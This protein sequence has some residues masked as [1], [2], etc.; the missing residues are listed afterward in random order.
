M[1]TLLNG[2]YIYIS[3]AG[4]NDRSGD[5]RLLIKQNVS[6]VTGWTELFGYS[7]NSTYYRFTLPQNNLVIQSAVTSIQYLFRYT[8]YNVNPNGFISGGTGVSRFWIVTQHTGTYQEVGYYDFVPY[9]K[10]NILTIKN[11]YTAAG[12]QTV[13]DLSWV[14]N[15]DLNTGHSIVVTFDTHNLLYQMFA[16]DLEGVGTNGATYRYLD[17]R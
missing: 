14:T 10:P 6:S 11:R 2:D 7:I 8:I 13:L 17:C 16:N 9:P 4:W 12:R 1:T 5:R 15:V 3:E